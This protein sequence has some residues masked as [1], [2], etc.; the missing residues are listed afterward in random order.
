MYYKLKIDKIAGVVL[1]DFVII[2]VEKLINYDFPDFIGTNYFNASEGTII[3]SSTLSTIPE[4]LKHQQILFDMIK[5][6][7]RNEKI[8]CIIK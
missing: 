6:F 7:L 8:E 1:K 3:L 5:P 2:S 4:I